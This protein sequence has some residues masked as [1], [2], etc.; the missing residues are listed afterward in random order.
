MN[1]PSAQQ[2]SYSQDENYRGKKTAAVDAKIGRTTIII[3]II[4]YCARA[5]VLARSGKNKIKMN[6]NEIK[7]ARNRIA[8]D[9]VSDSSK[10]DGA[11]Q[12][13]IYNILYYNNDRFAC[14]LSIHI[15]QKVPTRNRIIIIILYFDDRIDGRHTS[16]NYRL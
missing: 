15:I 5:A 12:V 11:F 3:C 16:D 1:R 4:K 10:V 7:T 9:T 6:R 2:S 8:F 13:P 14:P